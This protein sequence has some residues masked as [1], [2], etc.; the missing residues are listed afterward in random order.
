VDS[1]EDADN[2]GEDLSSDQEP[3]KPP[4]NAKKP[5]KATVV[6][7]SEES[8]HDSSEVGSD[9][10][11]Q[12]E[13]V[14][15]VTRQQVSASMGALKASSKLKSPRGNGG[16]TTG[17]QRKKVVSSKF[18]SSGRNSDHFHRLLGKK[19]GTLQSATS[20]KFLRAL[21]KIIKR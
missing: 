17:K 5:T 3:R 9:D 11:G 14:L 15:G 16:T 2:R 10:E 19:C 4:A 21:W 18:K 6:D 20:S 12:L 1:E 7:S 13:Q 8:V